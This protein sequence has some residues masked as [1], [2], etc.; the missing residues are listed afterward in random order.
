MG[1][2]NGRVAVITGGAS[3]IGAATVRLFVQEGSRVLIA[4]MLDQKG[5]CLAQDH[6]NYIAGF[7][8]FLAHNPQV[9]KPLQEEVKQWD[10]AKDE[11]V[12]NDNWPHQLYIL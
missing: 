9:P 1:K 10:M 3:G 5:E 8:Y 12:D 4:D 11:F 6:I 7:F 2:M